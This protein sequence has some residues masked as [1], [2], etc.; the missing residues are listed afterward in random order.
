MK[1]NQ[2]CLGTVNFGLEYG[3][4][5]RKLTLNEIQDL[6]VFSQKNDIN[7]LD[8]ARGY[9]DSE[10]ILG[11]FSYL[12]DKSK[13]VSKLSL[14]NLNTVDEV[15][16]ELRDSLFRLRRRNIHCVLLHDTAF[17]L[18][19]AGKV[20]LFEDSMLRAIELGIIETF[21][22]S[23]YDL[24]EIMKLQDQDIRVMNL[25]VPE[26]IMD[27]RLLNANL[28]SE[29]KSNGCVIY[30]R[31]LFL[32]GLLSDK[33]N[34]NQEFI[35]A[36]MQH[37]LEIYRLRCSKVGLPP[38]VAALAYFNSLTWAS[39]AVI[40]CDSKKQLEENLSTLEFVKLPTDFY[41]DLPQLPLRLVD[42]RRWQ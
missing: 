36:E 28:L 2:I 41:L 42:P 12:V 10:S 11:N 38:S 24:N 1:K 27:R 15:L 8:T 29:L 6:L 21:G 34:I 37:F 14:N 32:Q 39:F 16:V 33:K 22:F 18:E 9:G 40:G 17:C 5:S 30:V 3:P 25:Q 31:S 26:N 20:K 4:N 35:G 19:Q 23:I 7:F 13:L